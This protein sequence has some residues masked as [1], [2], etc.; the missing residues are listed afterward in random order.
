MTVF[1]KILHHNALRILAI[2]PVVAVAGWLLLAAAPRN[3]TD[4]SVPEAR[5]LP[6]ET[7]RL[8]ESDAYETPRSYTGT[9]V[10]QRRAELSFIRTGRLSELAAD[11]GDVVTAGDDLAR[12]DQRHLRQQRRQLEAQLAGARARLAELEQGPRKETIAAARAELRNQ[13]AQFDSVQANYTRR[14]KLLDDQ[15]ISREEFD[16][17]S[18]GARAAEARLDRAQRALD[19]LLAGTRVEQLVAQQAV[20]DELEAALTDV[21]YDFDDTILRAPFDGTILSRLVDEGT[22]IAPG[23]PV[24]RLVETGSLEAWV[25]LPPAIALGL[26]DGDLQRIT[27]DGEKYDATLVSRLPELDPTTRTQTVVLRFSEPVS[28]GLLAE[29]VV[30]LELPQRSRAKGF[31]LPLEALVA[32]PRGLWNAYAVMDG[33]VETRQ[34]EVLHTDAS[35]AF[36]RGTLAADEEIIASGTHR[37][38]EGQRVVPVA[39]TKD[40]GGR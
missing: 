4:R 12:L 31:W 2:V 38:V 34:V 23:T 25:G 7:M 13:Q 35:R 11:E 20:V 19:E 6:V 33:I 22:V 37:V 32:G 15:I 16:E 36:V 3:S 1:Q 18:F 29:Q 17:F 27:I 21:E 39:S 24:Y 30:R 5:P 40:G 10:A 28:G 26:T 9:I 8:V 14:E